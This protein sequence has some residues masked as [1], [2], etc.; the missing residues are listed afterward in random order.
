MLS[1]R[2]MFVSNSHYILYISYICDS[3]RSKRYDRTASDDIQLNYSASI[4]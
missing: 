4:Q 1:V 3:R 2:S